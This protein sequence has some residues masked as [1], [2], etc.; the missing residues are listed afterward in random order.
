MSSSLVFSRALI[1]MDAP[2][3]SIEVHLSSGLPAFNIVGLPE[4]AVK[5]SRDR[6]RSA[7]M[8]NQFDMPAKRITVNLAP[9]DLPKQSGRYDLPIA[10][11]LLVA[12]GVLPQSSVSGVE[13]IGELGLM[14][15]VR[16]CSGVLPMA[17]ACQRAGHQMILPQAN[18]EEAAL[19]AAIVQYPAMHLL[20]VVAHLKQLQPIAAYQSNAASVSEQVRVDL[21][22]VVGHE[23]AKRALTVAAAGGHSVLMQGPPG[24]GKS[25]L[26]QRMPSLLPAMGSDEAIETAVLYSISSQSEPRAWRER[27]FRAPHHSASAVAL[28]GGGSPPQPGEV[29]LAHHGVLFL[30]ELLEFSRPVLEALREPLENGDIAIS[31]AA[32]QARFPARFQLIAAMNP[33]PC[34]YLTDKQVECR[35]SC[36]QI[37][38]YRAKL[39]GP[40]LD[41][42]D[43]HIE[44]ARQPLDGLLA[45]P[46][47]LSSSGCL[48]EKVVNARRV[49]QSRQGK[50]NSALVAAELRGASWLGGHERRFLIDAVDQLAL[51]ARSFF[52]ILRLARSIAD[53][54]Q[55]ERVSKAC[56]SEALSW[57]QLAE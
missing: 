30:D 17:L 56:I 45:M 21:A 6:V 43:M 28:V 10:I 38:R 48:R 16:C 20:D 37:S 27:P 51:S 7:L 25:M 12:Q 49:Q 19:V 9:A 33:C 14:G 46:L 55:S 57:R 32:F 26:A 40:I 13:L 36:E 44:V 4:K 31:R 5:E 34:G 23:S 54:D 22:D 11:G 3:V 53:L 42:I 29:S 24:C 52:R 2:T 8:N 18:A 35:C 47:P 50:L 15:D 41:R 1:G 39:S